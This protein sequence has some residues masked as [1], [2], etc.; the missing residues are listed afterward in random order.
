VATFTSHKLKEEMGAERIKI[1]KELQD[2]IDSNLINC[3]FTI[4]Y[5]KPH[6]A[7]ATLLLPVAPPSIQSLP[8]SLSLLLS[9]LLLLLLLLHALLVLAWA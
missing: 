8:L 2:S 6:C 4:L 1:T 3:V 5:I 9:L 7:S